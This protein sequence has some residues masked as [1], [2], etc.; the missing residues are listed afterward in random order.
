[1]PPTILGGRPRELRTVGKKSGA[2]PIS[3][4]N[5]VLFRLLRGGATRGGAQNK[6]IISSHKGGGKPQ[7]FKRVFF[8]SPAGPRGPLT[9]PHRRKGGGTGAGG[10]AGGGPGGAPVEREL[11][12][13]NRN[14]K[15]GKKPKKKTAGAFS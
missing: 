3:M 9:G 1:M 10:G 4:K 11:W 15:E 7:R 5:G 2:R 8:F 14:P 13:E 6:N 12:G